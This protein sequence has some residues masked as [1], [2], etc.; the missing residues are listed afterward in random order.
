MWRIG[1][2]VEWRWTEVGGVKRAKGVV[3]WRGRVVNWGRTVTRDR[4]TEEY[5]G[6]GAM[7]KASVR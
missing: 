2:E 3:E 7:V 1:R 4:I 6:E 5:G